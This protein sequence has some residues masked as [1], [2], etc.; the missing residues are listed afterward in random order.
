[1]YTTPTATA[2]ELGV[3]VSTIRNWARAG[4]IAFK[5][6]PGGHHRYDISTVQESRRKPGSY[7]LPRT[8]KAIPTPEKKK[9]VFGAI[10]CRV[11]SAKQ[12]EDLQRQI[13]TLREQY[14][15]Y[16][17]FSDICSGLQYKRKGLSRLLECVQAGTIKE[18]VVA[19]KD[20]LARFGTELIEWILRQA[21]ATLIVLDK[22]TLSPTEEVTQDLMAIVHVFSCRLN[23]QRRY[24]SS[25]KKRKTS[26]IGP[27]QES[28]RS[29][30]SQ[31]KG[32]IGCEETTDGRSIPNG[33]AVADS[34]TTSVPEGMVQG[35]EVDIQ[36]GTAICN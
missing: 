3:S 13:S 5:T 1:M 32:I 26:T 14:P 30:S 21:G 27:I 9:P 33:G 7:N 2:H 8:T 23:G 12:K 6:T 4:T 22:A 10:Y 20:R 25:H 15:T 17:E 31:C 29:G 24:K 35:R 16:Q 18:V 28:K 34:Q 19:H 36:P 11:S